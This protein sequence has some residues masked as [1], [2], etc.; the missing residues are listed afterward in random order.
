MVDCV[1][2]S[3]AAD[4]Q[5]AYAHCLMPSMVIMH[6]PLYKSLFRNTYHTVTDCDCP[7]EGR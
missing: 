5:Y 4:K 6:P 7:L 1:H 2:S 3:T